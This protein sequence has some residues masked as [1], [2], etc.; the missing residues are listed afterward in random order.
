TLQPTPSIS[1]RINFL[2]I[3]L[4]IAGFTYAQ[5]AS[6][7]GKVFDEYQLPLMDVSVSDGTQTVYTDGDGNFAIEIT[8]GTNVSIQ[9]EQEGK[10]TFTE[11]VNIS[12]GETLEKYII[13]ATSVQLEGAVIFQ[14][15]TEKPLNSISLDPAA[16]E[17]S[18]G[19]TGGV[20]EMLGSLPSVSIGSELTSQY[21]VR[22]GNFDE[23]LI[24]V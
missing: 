8:A 5:Q 18:V 13:L 11:T 6:F 15:V 3:F 4:L 24:Y 19:L 17:T 16:M 23:N 9:F 22:G 20:A 2:V 1:I 14:R 12:E 7:K 21:R 10:S